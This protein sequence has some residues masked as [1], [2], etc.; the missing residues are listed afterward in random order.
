M[1][2]V[3][4]VVVVLARSVHAEPGVL[5][6]SQKEL[7]DAF[8]RLLEKLDEPV[9]LVAR[10]ALPRL[11]LAAGDVVRAINGASPLYDRATDRSDVGYRSV[12]WLDIV[13]RGRPLVIRLQ[14]AL[15][16]T[17]QAMSRDR[18]LDCIASLRTSRDDLLAQVMRGGSPS[19]VLVRF[20]PGLTLLLPGDVVRKVNGAAVT[21]GDGLIEALD[22]G[23]DRPAIT[24]ELERLGRPA[25][26]TLQIHDVTKAIAHITRLGDL[27]YEVPRALIDGIPD[28]MLKVDDDARVEPLRKQGRVLGT[29]LR[30]IR[31]G[32]VFQQL[33]YIDGDTVLGIDDAEQSPTRLLYALV[34]LMQ[35][36]GESG[37]QTVEIAINRNGQVVKLTYV[38]K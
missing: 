28:A 38:I 3:L 21:T 2:W 23:K 4:L 25:V 36:D 1:K 14:V 5:S 19:G 16:G 22:R 18:L 31:P 20:A 30:Q 15:D 7:A 9:G 12:L 29:T 6:V 13:R 34:V 11:G 32:S 8:D 33:G 27:R 37:A 10:V 26:V 24:I 35:G 17:S